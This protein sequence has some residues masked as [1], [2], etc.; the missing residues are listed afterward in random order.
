MSK[1]AVAYASV[2]MGSKQQKTVSLQRVNLKL[3]VARSHAVYLVKEKFG[4]VLRPIIL[5]QQNQRKFEE[6]EGRVTWRN[7]FAL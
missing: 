2:L 1:N 3:F 4:F 5:E 6:D 7:G